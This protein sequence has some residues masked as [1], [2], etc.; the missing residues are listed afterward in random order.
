MEDGG[1]ERERKDECSGNGVRYG[2]TTRHPLTQ[3]IRGSVQEI[4]VLAE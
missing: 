2:E 4:S 3:T 1:D